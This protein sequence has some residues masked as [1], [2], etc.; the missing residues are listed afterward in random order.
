MEFFIKINFVVNRYDNFCFTKNYICKF[1][2]WRCN[3]VLKIVIG[4]QM[5]EFF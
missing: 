2:I 3:F 5:D 4:V 1:L